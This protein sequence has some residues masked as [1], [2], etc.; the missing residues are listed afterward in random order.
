MFSSMTRSGPAASAGAGGT[1]R[2]VRAI[3]NTALASTYCAT[4]AVVRVRVDKL[5]TAARGSSEEPAGRTLAGLGE[6]LVHLRQRHG[7]VGRG[8][9]R[10]AGRLGADAPDGRVGQAQRAHDADAGEA[11]VLVVV[12]ARVVV[13]AADDVGDVLRRR[14]QLALRPARGKDVGRRRRLRR[15]RRGGPRRRRRR[16]DAGGA[17]TAA[18]RRMLCAARL[19][20]IAGG[21][22]F[23]GGAARGGAGASARA[24]AGAAAFSGGAGAAGSAVAGAAAS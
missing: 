11:H 18:V 16:G 6:V 10:A 24:G 5:L 22:G 15:R 13:G 1:G 9:E 21:R 8:L 19:G 4:I 14:A 23:S 17:R 3:D 20:R 2:G 12:R 7:R